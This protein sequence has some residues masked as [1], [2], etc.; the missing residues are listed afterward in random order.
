[1]NDDFLAAEDGLA[2]ALERSEGFQILA[3]AL[4]DALLVV[5]PNGTIAYAS[6]QTRDYFGR[7]ATD[8]IGVPL[9]DLVAKEDRASFPVPITS[10]QVGTWD[11]RPASE[12][13]GGR[14]LNAALLHPNLQG[15]RGGV[16]DDALGDC[17]LVLVRDLLHDHVGARDRT[18]LLRRSLDATN[19]LIVVTDPRGGDNPLVI[20][21]DHF[22]EAT[23]Y[24]REEVI[25]RNCRFLQCRADGTRDDDQEGVLEL[26][27][28]VREG[29]PAHVVLRN[30]KKDGEL[31]YNE[32]FVSPVFDRNGEVINFIGVQNDV[33]ERI[34]AERNA[35]TQTG[36]LRAFFD[37]SP[38][39][40]GVV[41][42]DSAGLVHRTANTKAVE[43]YGI[44]AGEV[45]GARSSGVGFT[46]SETR[47]WR[48]AVEECAETREAVQFETVHPWDDDPEGEGV[49]TLTITVSPVTDQFESEQGD[50]YSYTG[51]D[52]TLARRRERERGL[53]AAAVEQAAEPILV[54]DAAIDAPGPRILYVNRAHQKTFGYTEDEVVGKTPRMFQGPKTDRAVLDRIRR[55]LEAGESTEAETVNYRKDGSE[56]IL[57]WELAPV[58]DESGEIRYWVGT[59]R[60]MTDRRSLEVEVLEAA[61]R[62]QER[63]A[64]DLHDGLGQV[65]VGASFRLQALR[66]ALLQPDADL[67][68][69]AGDLERTQGLVA[70]GLAQ[71]RAIARGL[72]P[73]DVAQG[74]LMSALSALAADAV[75]AYGI[76]CSFEADAP[77]EVVGADGAGHLY[78]LVQ[79]ALSNAVRHGRAETVVIEAV[80]GPLALEVAIRDDGV[81][82]SEDALED[83]DGLGLRTMRYR[84]RRIG[85][86]L[87]IQ[88]LAGGG[89][90]VCLRVPTAPEDD[91]R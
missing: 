17:S 48:A 69:I 29:R 28:A 27:A 76:A 55:A 79:E 21:N 73:A 58:R 16:L 67:E 80:H 63:M 36:L 86:T 70:G 18:D 8:L 66:R 4:P 78:R 88:P 7:P 9:L 10:I 26:T 87:E 2:D 42:L 22:L 11:F 59:Q 72:A 46:E 24:T 5:R 61:T 82:I 39:L 51:E 43:L 6:L 33:T 31:F 1:M 14:W 75:E 15:F 30:Y 44:E 41:Q 12:P 35:L 13:D 45:P 64:R 53:L 57:Q 23:G 83:A 32:L 54:T 56:F 25:G 89:T 85:G 84:A 47:K 38:L 20:V 19:N 3:R 60:D 77:I 34:L 62:E 81:G 90:E 74:G 65:L 37:S 68:A 50:L 49:R 40:M 91:A 52:V 71:A